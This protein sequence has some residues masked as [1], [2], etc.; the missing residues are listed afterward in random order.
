M[1]SEAAQAARAIQKEITDN[2]QGNLKR[3]L[4]KYMYRQIYNIKYQ[5]HI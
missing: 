2:S 1:Q 5:Y 3:N 4:T